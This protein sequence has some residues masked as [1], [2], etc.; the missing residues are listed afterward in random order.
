MLLKLQQCSITILFEILF[1][2]SH[3]AIELQNIVLNAFF[4]K[5]NVFN[6]VQYCLQIFVLSQPCAPAGAA[7]GS[8]AQ[9]CRHEPE[10][11]Q[12]CCDV[13]HCP[14]R[15]RHNTRRCTLLSAAKIAVSTRIELLIMYL[16]VF[17]TYSRMY[18]CI[19]I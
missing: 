18:F 10:C 5:Y 17:Y 13:L 16:Y 6:V 9:P 8:Q 14:R 19:R 15:W 11:W 1:T 4:L 2:M 7:G 12:Q 3:V